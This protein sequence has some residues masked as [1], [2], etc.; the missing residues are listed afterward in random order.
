MYVEGCAHSSQIQTGLRAAEVYSQETNDSRWF[1][2][3]RNEASGAIE[4]ITVD[5]PP[6][7]EEETFRDEKGIHGQSREF[8]GLLQPGDKIALMVVGNHPGYIY[9]L[10]YASIDIFYTLPNQSARARALV[11][12]RVIPTAKTRNSHLPTFATSPT[13]VTVS[14]AAD[15]TTDTGPPAATGPVNTA[16]ATSDRVLSPL[17]PTKVVPVAEDSVA[18]NESCI[19][20]TG[21]A[22]DTVTVDGAPAQLPTGAVADG[23]DTDVLPTIVSPVDYPP[24]ATSATLIDPKTSSTSSAQL[25][26]QHLSIQSISLES[27]QSLSETVEGLTASL[28]ALTVS[29]EEHL[30]AIQ[31]VQQELLHRIDTTQ[32]KLET[33]LQ[34]TNQKFGDLREYISNVSSTH[35]CPCAASV[36]TEITSLRELVISL[37]SE[38]LPEKQLTLNVTGPSVIASAPFVFRM[39]LF[40]HSAILRLVRCLA[41]S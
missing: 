13:P 37:L 26:L 30:A 22:K 12:C 18:R 25:T 15:E 1:I 5:W 17:F 21:K 3:E 31:H 11:P 36:Q 9:R 7:E 35:N 38:L 10:Q 24:A 2:S 28:K 6:M 8:I 29:T 4:E 23:P 14:L 33:A 34:V 27:V 19:S 40:R 41:N 20:P 32:Q 39:W 16:I